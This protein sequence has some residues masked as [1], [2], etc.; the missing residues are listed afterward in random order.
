MS[1]SMENLIARTMY[2]QL[3]VYKY[4]LYAKAYAYWAGYQMQ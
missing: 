1:F 2:I 4:G 3:E